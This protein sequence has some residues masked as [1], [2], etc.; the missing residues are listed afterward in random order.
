MAEAFLTVL[1]EKLFERLNSPEF[2]NFFQGKK[3]ICE[4]LRELNLKLKTASLLVNDAEERQL[5]EPDVKDWLDD[6]KHVIY[7]TQDLVDHIDYQL[8]SNSLGHESGTTDTTTVLMKMKFFFSSLTEF[9][10]TVQVEIFK[11]LVDIKFLLQKR[12]LL[13]LKEDTQN[14]RSSQRSVVSLREQHHVHVHGRD[15]DKDKIMEWLITNEALGSYKIGVLPI[16][17]TGGLGKTTLARLVYNDTK[18][19]EHGFE[20]KVW[21]TVSA[22]FDVIKAMKIILHAATNSHSTAD[23]DVSIKELRRR[24]KEA[25]RGK[26]YLI[27]LDNVWD[28][29]ED[30]W[31]VLKPIFTSGACESRIIVTTRS[32]QVAI[33]VGTGKSYE[34]S[35]VSPAHCW[36]IFID[37]AFNG[38]LDTNKH[39]QEIGRIVVE[40]CK[41]LPLALISLGGLLRFEENS[42]KWEKILRSHVWEWCESQNNNIV[43]SLW[44]SYRYPPSYLKQCFAYCSMFPKNHEFE[45]K[46]VVLLWMAEGFLE[47]NQL[48]KRLEEVGEEYFDNLVSRSLFQRSSRDDSKFIM[49]DLVH[50]LAMFVSGE[51]CMAVEDDNSLEVLSNKTRHLSHTTTSATNCDSVREGLSRAQNLRTWTELSIESRNKMTVEFFVER[52]FLRVLSLY[53][54]SLS[55]VLPDSISKL[56]HLRYLDLSQ[57]SIIELPSSICILYNLQTLLLSC[58]RSLRRLPKDMG[59]L[60][61]LRHL[62]TIGSPL[63]EMPPQMG[64]LKKLQ[65]LPEFVLGKGHDNASTIREL[66]ELQQLSGELYIFGLQNVD[67]VNDALGANLRCKEKL[68]GLTFYWLGET[69]DTRRESEVL[70][71]LQPHTNLKK[72]K[73]YS[74]AGFNFPNWIGDSSF[75]NVV[76]IHLSHNKNCWSL[77]SL[78]QLPSLQNLVIQSFHGVETIGAEFYHGNNPSNNITPFQSLETLTFHDMP[79][80]KVWSPVGGDDRDGGVLTLFP[81]LKELSLNGCPV[82]AGSLPDLDT[83]ETLHISGVYGSYFPE[84]RSPTSCCARN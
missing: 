45:K 34:L 80:W 65:M 21:A 32:Q 54:F 33:I 40:K 66:G 1:F 11:I 49:H 13:G 50:D 29:N 36:K 6:L 74:Y 47:D 58:C 64:N 53:S 68:T 17:G 35:Q 39:L 59:R 5:K 70:E 26:K 8:L 63:E 67:N 41:G 18:L 27:V 25:L 48:E 3:S 37:H 38:E 72:L 7:R 76:S 20:L 84:P 75:S 56:K 46:G 79:A 4:Q 55:F 28:E 69:M 10:K 30:N 62:D 16:V 23:I 19:K 77:P 9:E 57:N 60:I 82:L 24:L 31:A 42:N 71:A 73:I 52:K 51:F 22:E 15:E 44:L 2:A 83:L 12:V 61:N 14:T 43:P 81:S 78:G